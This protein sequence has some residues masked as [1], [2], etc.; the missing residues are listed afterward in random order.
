MLSIKV[1]KFCPGQKAMWICIGV[2]LLYIYN[3]VA[4]L[5]NLLLYYDHFL[6]DAANEFLVAN[7][8]DIAINI[9]K[10]NIELFPKSFF[11]YDVLAQTYLKTD[12]KTNT[13]KYFKMLLVL[14]SDNQKVK[15]TVVALENK[16]DFY[17]RR[18]LGVKL[19]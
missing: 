5:L 9:Y 13:L 6:N 18:P 12:Y 4:L 17:F 15:K 2:A 8:T 1:K 10:V 14:D 19:F 16:I 3:Y 7:K 11:T